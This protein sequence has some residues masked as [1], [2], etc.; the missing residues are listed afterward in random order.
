MRSMAAVAAAAATAAPAAA[1]ATAAARTSTRTPH[2]PVFL[3]HE[4]AESVLSA[5]EE[6]DVAEAMLLSLQS[7]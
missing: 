3:S 2:P 7:S 6:R 4:Q 1:P 5:A